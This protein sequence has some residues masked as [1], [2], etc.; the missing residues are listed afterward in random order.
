MVFELRQNIF[1]TDGSIWVKRGTY[2]IVSLFD[3]ERILINVGG[4]VRAL[5]VVPLWKGNVIRRG[6][7][8]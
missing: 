1:A 2:P 3:N 4:A 8:S 7:N 5:V 6:A